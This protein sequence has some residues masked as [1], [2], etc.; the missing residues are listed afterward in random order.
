MIL[1]EQWFLETE[2]E[3]GRPIVTTLGDVVCITE[4][5]H[6][7]DDEWD[8]KNFQAIATLPDL[9]TAIL[10]FVAHVAAAKIAHGDDTLSAGAVCRGSVSFSDFEKLAKAFAKV[11]G[12][13]K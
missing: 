6:S 8:R 3:T 2:Q 11:Q 4:P 5:N 1:F 9:V 13:A 10:P 7:A 12:V